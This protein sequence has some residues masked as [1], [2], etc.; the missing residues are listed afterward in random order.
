MYDLGKLDLP[1]FVFFVVSLKAFLIPLALNLGSYIRLR[2][3][4]WR[5]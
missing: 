5:L 1:L 3:A 2:I 4:K